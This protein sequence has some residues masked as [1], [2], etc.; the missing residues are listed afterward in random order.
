MKIREAGMRLR[1]AGAADAEAVALLHTTSWRDAYSAVLDPAY[2][3]GPVEEERRA[4][5]TTE[6]HAADEGRQVI[7]AE[8]HGAAAGF[9]CVRW[10]GD[11]PWGAWVNNL[12][13]V[14][15]SRG[16]GAGKQLLKAAAAW[17][18]GID[19]Q[20]GLH[21]WVLEANDAARAFYRHL[22]GEVAGRGASQIA[23]A[24]GAPILRVWWRRAAQLLNG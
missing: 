8:D 15:A 6:L 14:R 20:S 22:G 24:N 10:P 11:P 4:Y 9:V 1:V 21:V 17:V 3:A 19:P 16:K 7:L 18:T 13:V 12:H 23:A 2:L 5:W